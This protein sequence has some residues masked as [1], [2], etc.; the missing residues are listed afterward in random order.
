MT[1]TNMTGA[2]VIAVDGPAASGKGTLARRLAE[3]LG[4]A[5]LDTGKLYRYVGRYV[6]DSGGAPA[7]EATATAM[8]EKI[9]DR[10]RPEELDDPRLS[11]H[12]AG[13]AASKVAQFTGVRQALYDYQLAFADTPPDNAPGAVIDGRDIGTVIVPDAAVKLYITASTRVRAQR[14][15]Q[16]LQTSNSATTYDTI[17]QDMYERDRR[18]AERESAPMKPAEDAYVIDTSDMDVAA[19]Y[20][21]VAEIVHN[22]LASR[23]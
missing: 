18:D 16:Q 11:G 14:R 13:N 15:Y 23:T 22:R 20:R 1:D 7:D 6:L 10:L 4:F 19:A 9:R 3:D 21:A 17:L 5:Y 2:S 8:A 12:E